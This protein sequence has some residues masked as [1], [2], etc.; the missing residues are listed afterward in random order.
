[1]SNDWWMV[2]LTGALVV[3]GIAQACLFLWQ[4]K[5]IKRSMSDNK[6]VAKAAQASADAALAAL[7]RPWL[8][9]EGF[10]LNKSAWQNGN[11]PLKAQFRISN[12]GKAPA[13]I[14]DLKI[15]HFRGPHHHNGMPPNFERYFGLSFLPRIPE[16][17]EFVS[18][19]DRY[20]KPLLDQ[21]GK[22]IEDLN[23][24]LPSKDN[25]PDL[26]VNGWQALD[27]NNGAIDP[28]FV[29][30]SYL[31]GSIFYDIPGQPSEFIHF[32]YKENMSDS[33]SL[34]KDYPPY[35]ERRKYS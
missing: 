30:E 20:S 15:V 1:M 35:N 25:T 2:W 6:I 3:V 13:V 28:I 23:F 16:P 19:V 32:C 34:F 18:F 12:Y 4:L 26:F 9:L 33:F 11:A 22:R 7:D 29:T 17:N 10:R 27:K 8:M 31:L 5:L 21:N 14:K 24:I